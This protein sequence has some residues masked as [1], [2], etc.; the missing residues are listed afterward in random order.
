MNQSDLLTL[1][2]CDAKCTATPSVF[3]HMVQEQDAKQGIDNVSSEKKTPVQVSSATKPGRSLL[4]RKVCA[5]KFSLRQVPQLPGRSVNRNGF[6]LVCGNPGQSLLKRCQ[7][8]TLQ[9]DEQP[10]TCCMS[11]AMASFHHAQPGQS[12]LKEHWA[13]HAPNMNLNRQPATRALR[14]TEA[15]IPEILPGQSILRQQQAI[16]VESP[17]QDTQPPVSNSGKRGHQIGPGQSLLKRKQEVSDLN[18]RKDS[19]SIVTGGI[20]RGVCR[21][22]GLHKYRARVCFLIPLQVCIWQFQLSDSSTTRIGQGESLLKP[23]A[24]SSRNHY[25]HDMDI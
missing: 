14:K 20:T 11:T 8:S 23:R 18:R 21:L 19:Q 2:N 6:D 16:C 7:A 13:V 10:A 9:Q 12:L 22:I 1:H 3:R 24:V 5:S 25:A 4:K 15:T 17:K